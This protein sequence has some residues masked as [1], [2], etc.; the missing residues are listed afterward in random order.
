MR[1]VIWTVILIWVVWKVYDAFKSVSRTRAQTQGYN[2]Q[3]NNYR[4][5]EGE[6][7]VDNSQSGKTHYKPD[8]G[9]YVDYEEIK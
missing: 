9:E 5:R 4:Q 7:R 1:D 8:D 2:Q 3:Q 6:V